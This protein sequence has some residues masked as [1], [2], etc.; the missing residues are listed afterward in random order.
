M[1]YEQITCEAADGIL[2]ITLDRPER[3]NAFTPRMAGELLDAFDRA[4]ADDDVRVVIMTG[5]GR[6]FCAGADLSSGAETFAADTDAQEVHRDRGGL[7][8]LR[9]FD[10]TKPIITAINGPAVG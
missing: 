8:T 10:L 4:D 9:I 5:R 2:T 6:A 7:V 1:T 3:L